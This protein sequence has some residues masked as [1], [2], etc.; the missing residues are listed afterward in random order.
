MSRT[1]W[2]WLEIEKT[3]DKAEIRRAYARQAKKYHPEDSPEEAKQLR[4][5]YKMALTLAGG[6][7]GSAVFSPEPKPEIP[8]RIQEEA[9]KEAPEGGPENAEEEYQYRR[10]DD[11]T[12]KEQPE[13]GPE[14]VG[15]EYQY[16]R[17]DDETRREQPKGRTEGAGEGYRYRGG[18]DGTR[19][20]Q[21]QGRTE[22]TEREY[23]YNVPSEESREER[24]RQL[25]ELLQELYQGGYQAP[26]QWYSAIKAY[27]TEE[28]LKD[29]HVVAAVLS[30]LT[31]MPKLR[32]STWD[33]FERELFCCC[34]EGAEWIWLK[35]QFVKMRKGDS[36]FSEKRQNDPALKKLSLKE[37]EVYV[38]RSASGQDP[39]IT[40]LIIFLIA[41]VVYC[42]MFM[43][44]TAH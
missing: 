35:A 21:P 34:G 18:S 41:M 31:Q 22:E 36:I 25:E 15:E 29:A 19:K 30:V 44:L 1:I 6:N 3:R 28:D 24:L 13:G 16:R 37:G 8:T 11:G 27:L 33:V 7:T 14:S 23:Q 17:H 38:E 39:R 40:L 43:A 32:F 12:R 4:E 10:Y 9:Q 5:A 42:C 2:E 20:E 26:E